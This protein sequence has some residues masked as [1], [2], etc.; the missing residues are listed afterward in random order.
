MEIHDELLKTY[1][2]T[3]YARVVDRPR[4]VLGLHS[5]GYLMMMS[6]LVKQ[7]PE[8]GGKQSFLGITT[9]VPTPTSGQDE[10][11]VIADGT[12]R[13]LHLTKGCTALFGTLP[14]WRRQRDATMP[15]LSEWIEDLTLEK[16]ADFTGSKRKT[17]IITIP[18]GEDKVKV[19]VSGSEVR[20]RNSLCYILKLEIR[21]IEDSLA[22][23]AISP[24]QDLGQCPFKGSQRLSQNY[25]S[26]AGK[27]IGAIPLAFSAGSLNAVHSKQ[28]GINA[29]PRPNATPGTGYLRRIIAQ[30]NDVANRRLR[31]LMGVILVGLL[32]LSALAVGYNLM[33][34]SQYDKVQEKI[35]IT[36]RRSS[37]CL[38]AVSIVDERVKSFEEDEEDSFGEYGSQLIAEQLN[39]TITR[40]DTGKADIGAEFTQSENSSGNRWLLRGRDQHLILP[41]A[42]LVLAL[43]LAF[44][45]S[46]GAL[47][48]RFVH[49]AALNARELFYFSQQPILSR[50]IDTVA[51]NLLLAAANIS[52][53]SYPSTS[54]PNLL[55]EFNTVHQALTYGSDSW[56]IPA[57]V[58]S[59]NPSYQSLMYSS[60][61]IAS[62]PSDCGTFDNGAMSQGLQSALDWYQQYAT[63]VMATPIPPSSLTAAAHPA[64]VMRALDFSYLPPLYTYLI[65]TQTAAVQNHAAWFHTYHLAATILFVSGMIISF[66]TLFRPLLRRLA[67]DVSRTHFMLFMIPPDVLGRVGVIQRWVEETREGENSRESRPFKDGPAVIVSKAVTE[68]KEE[69]V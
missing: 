37:A 19:I 53:G 2:E 42:G 46:S 64:I 15:F 25:K 36:A 49:Q 52:T 11:Y 41:K 12:M 58:V 10:E 68:Q 9:P 38:D 43:C 33:Y 51:R 24:H 3:G 32:A 62:S 5:S 1:L 54:L 56:G 30:K 34:K 28:K 60:G 39:E 29:G 21:A 14:L 7:I 65:E 4:Q 18:G 6:L 66:L 22:L 27:S 35:L 16:V 47:T 20:V 67:E 8:P 44:F 69:M 26:H 59:A 50:Q 63:L 45:L 48:V 61:C 13:V 31:W 23:P 17:T 55:A 57:D 40:N